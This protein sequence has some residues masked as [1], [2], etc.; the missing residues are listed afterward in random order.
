MLKCR[1]TDSGGIAVESNTP[2]PERA[3]VLD[4]VEARQFANQLLDICSEVDHE[5]LAG[6]TYKLIE[7][8][9]LLNG[10]N[11]KQYNAIKKM[12]LDSN[13]LSDNQLQFLASF[14]NFFSWP[15]HT[16]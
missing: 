14:L 13:R 10:T 5:K 15:T 3:D 6:I 9:H 12:I 1:L 4:T 8:G 16:L 11:Q 7:I 2:E